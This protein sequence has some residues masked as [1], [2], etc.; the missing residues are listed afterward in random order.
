MTMDDH[1]NLAAPKTQE[2]LPKIREIIIDRLARADPIDD[3]L[4]D[5]CNQ[6]GIDWS[7][8]E[9]LV[10]TVQAEREDDITLHQSPILLILSVTTFAAGAGLFLYSASVIGEILYVLSKLDVRLEDLKLTILPYYLESPINPIL[11]LITGIGMMG[12]GSLGMKP[13]WKVI[14]SKMG[15]G[16]HT[17]D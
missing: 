9:D 12:G 10:A 3:I 14:L 1:Q 16:G 11:A 6:E 15:I 7:E 4:L 8:A 5:L 17:Q 2:N 13:I